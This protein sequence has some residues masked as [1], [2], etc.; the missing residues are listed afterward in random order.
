MNQKQKEKIARRILKKNGYTK[1][2]IAKILR[3]TYGEKDKKA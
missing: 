3:L 2:E 1:K